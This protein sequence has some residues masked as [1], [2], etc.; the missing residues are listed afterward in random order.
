[1]SAA[2]NNVTAPDAYTPAA[3]LSCPAT[4]RVRLQVNNGAIYWQRGMRPP[5]GGGVEWIE[6]EE[7]LLPTVA[8]L[9]ERCDVIRVR[10]AVKAAELPTGSSP[11]QVT[12]T[13]RT[14]AELGGVA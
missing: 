7:F 6:P 3:T 11:A 5:A 12:I 1:M 4:A 8:S 13:T 10:A 2:L 9:D 14:A